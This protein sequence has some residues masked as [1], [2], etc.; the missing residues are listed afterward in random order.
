MCIELLF[1]SS[2]LNAT[3]KLSSIILDLILMIAVKGLLFPF[4]VMDSKGVGM[5]QFMTCG[6]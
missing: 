3:W 6:V 4:I 2:A 5:L 1:T